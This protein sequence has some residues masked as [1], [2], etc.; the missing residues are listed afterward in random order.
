MTVFIL[1]VLVLKGKD[2]AK[3]GESNKNDKFL[4][5]DI[6]TSIGPKKR[7]RPQT[8]QPQ[9]FSYPVLLNGYSCRCLY[10]YPCSKFCVSLAPCFRHSGEMKKSYPAGHAGGRDRACFLVGP[11]DHDLYLLVVPGLVD[12]VGPG[13]HDLLHSADPGSPCHYF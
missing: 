2:K 10:P 9:F 3:I 12:P 6:I 8:D 1:N 5:P 4:L 13:Y 11:C 7:G